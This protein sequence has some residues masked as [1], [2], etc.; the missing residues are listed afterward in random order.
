M[1]KSETGEIATMIANINVMKKKIVLFVDETS[2][3][4]LGAGMPKCIEKLSSQ[5]T[6]RTMFHLVIHALGEKYI[7]VPVK[8]ALWYKE[9]I[10][11]IGRLTSIQEFSVVLDYTKHCWLYHIEVKNTTQMYNFN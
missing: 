9:M 6:I 1:K 4:G 7:L 5:W 11:S 8:D 3:D 2:S 10:A